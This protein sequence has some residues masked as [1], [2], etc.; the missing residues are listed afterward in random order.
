MPIPGEAD[1]LF[2]DKVVLEKIETAN[3]FISPQN[4]RIYFICSE[5][6]IVQADLK[7]SLRILLI[8]FQCSHLLGCQ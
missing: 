8:L 5:T 3:T 2:L 7:W 6:G 4:G 1:V